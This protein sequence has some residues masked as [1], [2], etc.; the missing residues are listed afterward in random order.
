M[1]ACGTTKGVPKGE[2][3]Q[4]LCAKS[5]HVFGTPANHR[6]DA[7]PRSAGCTTRSPNA[8]D[9]TV[10]IAAAPSITA[11]VCRRRQLM[12]P[13]APCPAPP[14]AWPE[15]VLQIVHMACMSED[16]YEPLV[17]S[18]DYWARASMKDRFPVPVPLPKEVDGPL[19]LFVGFRGT[20][21][22]ALLGILFCARTA[23][24]CLLGQRE[25]SSKHVCGLIVEV[26][27]WD[28]RHSQDPQ[29]YCGGV[30]LGRTTTLLRTGC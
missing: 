30:V 2:G 8:I 19:S 18:F 1:C 26:C 9:P 22:N 12:P 23:G 28:I 29:N 3:V 15:R 27:M 17:L 11:A 24:S 16:T 25:N 20:T 21:E 5:R 10:P 7:V 14:I 4:C 13:A 6:F